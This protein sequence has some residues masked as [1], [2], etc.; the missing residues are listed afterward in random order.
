MLMISKLMNQNE[1]SRLHGCFKM[2]TLQ[3][4][5]LFLAMITLVACNSKKMV[6]VPVEPSAE[7][8]SV[9]Y[10]YRPS[11]TT[12]VM[13]IPKVSVSGAKQFAIASDEYKLI[14]LKPGKHA[15][16]LHEIKGSTAAVDH[17]L[18]IAK[19]QVHYLRVDASMKFEAGQNYKPYQR[20]FGLTEVSPELAKEE[21]A[22]VK[23][24]DGRKVKRGQK[25]SQAGSSRDE[26]VEEEE[27]TFSVD[28]T[29]N[30]FNH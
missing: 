1:A 29:L 27:A 14:F 25:V 5:V 2:N 13:Q 16:R 18:M 7:E 3:K 19:G 28:R 22:G 15:V 23:D 11:K 24:M 6:F 26:V 20:S 12:N 17:E 21:I 30:P 4:V 9:L 10:V 8:G